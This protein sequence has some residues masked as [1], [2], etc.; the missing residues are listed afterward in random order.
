M[1]RLAAGMN[2]NQ[3]AFV[4][5][6]NSVAERMRKSVNVMQPDLVDGGH[7]SVDFLIRNRQFSNSLTLHTSFTLAPFG[8]ASVR[9]AREC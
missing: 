2:R 7:F 6:G 8:K 4:N 5:D 9:F 1:I 3:K